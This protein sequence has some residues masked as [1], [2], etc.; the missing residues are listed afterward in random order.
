MIK[1]IYDALI[2][3]YPLAVLFAVLVFVSSLGYYSSKLE[4][5]AS[6]ETLLLEDDKDLAFFREVNKTY[7]NSNFLV[8]TFSP[9]EELLSKKSLETLKNISDDFLKVKN[10]E[11]IT[12]ILNV[13][14]LQSPIRPISDLVAGV[15]SLQTK[16]FDKNLVKNELLN[17]P[18]YSNSLVSSDFKT[19][20]IILNLK[21]DTKYFE[22]L[23]KRNALLSKEKNDT[24][25]KEEKD[26]LKKTIIEF[27]NYRDYLRIEE[28]KEIEQI[29]EI[30]NSYENEAKIFLGGVNMIASDIIGYVKNDLIIY[31]TS[32]LLILIFIL[33]YIFRHIRWIILPLFI[34]LISVIST[35]GVLGLFAWEV[36]VISSNFIA[37][38]LIIT[39]SIVL[40]LIVR[41]R[42]L[43]VKYKNASQ[44]KLIINTILSKINPSFFAIITT[45][46]GFGSL[47]LSNIEPVI[48]LGLMMSTGIAISLFLAF[49]TF[50]AILI[51]M[52]KKDEHEQKNIRFS[53]IQK[54]SDVVEHK[55][56]TIIIV[57]T[58]VILFSL[59]GALKLVVENSFISYF[60]ETTDIY[61][62]M[63]VID[64]NLG[65]T[66][67]LDIIIKFKNEPKAQIVQTSNDEFDDFENEFAQSAND[68]QYWFSQDK[69]D[70][71]TAIHE[72]L[73][74]IPE[75]GKVQSLA[76]LLKI[77]ESLNNGRK[78]DG[79]TLALLYN[80]MPSNYKSLILSP[81]INIEKNEARITMR[82]L[83]S[84]PDLRRNDLI[85]K[86]NSDL[87]EIIKNKETTYQLSNL[88]I[89]YNN[90]LQ[91]LFDSQIATLGFVVIILFIMFLI[92][93][94][95]IKVS[96]IALIANIIPISVIFGIMGWLNIP[97][98]IMTI[99]IAAIAI[100][101]GVDDTIHFI[102]RF[103]E[104]F[105]IDHNYVNA[106]RRSHE[107]IGYAMYYTSLVIIMGFSILV[108]S[109]LIPTIYFGLL[110]VVTMFTV[111]I[112]DL[113]LLPKLL[114]IFK[115]YEKLKENK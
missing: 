96:L 90:M 53:F 24:I 107:T 46:S 75:I 69:M 61:K 67:P 9:K 41:Y 83:D 42:E 64:E 37:L 59:S 58:L 10:I 54:C 81:F 51:L 17:S 8:V 74:T 114:L 52:D 112:A 5:D 1:K 36:T 70:T 43:N 113:L 103:K 30:I 35:A 99:T 95:S 13:P 29:R 109:N 22:L 50:P 77:G 14:L 84:N 47:V 16:E 55:T 45:I 115:P 19:T 62:G 26:E 38:Q 72:Y 44:Y 25:S 101:I 97:L 18:L 66:T 102:H 33:W 32:L 27:K 28:A 73:E 89:L 34:C 105:K 104:E 108:L 71:I 49:I 80:Q 68:E 21:T 93:F 11:S 7:D 65:G 2:L 87:K 91:S 12:S 79:I 76:T 57:T 23:E 3:K 85:S 56:K 106:M 15:D 4:I 39:I 111:L 82:I 98:D 20:A 78:L 88:M 100:G 6:A 31:G 110:T 63:K 48:N 60:K 86:I 40:H 94:R 92:L